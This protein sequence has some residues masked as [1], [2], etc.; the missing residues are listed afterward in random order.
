MR[1]RFINLGVIL[2]GS[3]HTVAACSQAADESA[4]VQTEMTSAAPWLLRGGDVNRASTM[5]ERN[6]NVWHVRWR[7]GSPPQTRTAAG[8]LITSAR[9]SMRSGRQLLSNSS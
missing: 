2:A 7:P 8:T 5:S 9:W 1:N 3:L 6:L 4:P